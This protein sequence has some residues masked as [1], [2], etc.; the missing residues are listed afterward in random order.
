[1]IRSFHLGAEGED[2]ALHLLDVYDLSQSFQPCLVVSPYDR[3][4]DELRRR[5][6]EEAAHLFHWQV[7]D[8]LPQR[9]RDLAAEPPPPNERPVLWLQLRRF[10]AGAWRSF[11]PLLQRQRDFY[12]EVAPWM[13]VLAG[14]PELVRLMQESAAHVL[15]GVSV[16]ISLKEEPRAL[17]RALRPVRW[18]HLSD[19]HFAADQR[20]HR[21]KTLTALLTQAEKLRAEGLAPDFV[22]LTGDVADTGKQA[23]YQQ[24]E[25]FCHALGEKLGLEPRESFFVVPGNH[26][27]DRDAIGPGDRHI[28][29]ALDD[30]V[31]V[32][33]ILDDRQTMNLLGRRLEGFYA[34]TERLLGPAR[35][36]RRDKPWRVEEREV[37]DLRVAVVQLNSAW[38]SGKDDSGGL[39]IGEAQAQEALTEAADAHLRVVLVHHP[40]ADLRDF[41]R[42]P[43]DSRLA[44]GD[45]HFLLRG[46]LH[47]TG[48]TKHESPD[49]TLIELA[50]GATYVDGDWPQGFLLTEVDAGA[51]EGRVRYFGFSA[52]GKGFWAKDTLSYENLPDGIWTFALPQALQFGD[53][54]PSAASSELTDA[55]RATATVRYRAAA[56]AVHG[57]VRFVGFADHRPR[58]NVT[59]PELFVPLRFEEG[60][61]TGGGDKPKSVTTPELLG[62][63][64]EREDEDRA[65]R[66]VVLG[67]PGSGKT[68]FCRFATT[69]LA[70]EAKLDGVDAGAEILPLFLA[71]RDYVREKTRSLVDFLE[72]Q[73]RSQLQLALPDGFLEAALDDGRAVLLLDGLDEVGSVAEREEI[74]GRVQAFFRRWPKVP[75]LVTS[76][77]AGYEDAPLAS[78]GAGACRHLR[79]AAFDDEDLKQFVAHWYAVQ[80]P[81]DPRARDEGIADLLAA[82]DASPPVR[83]LAR[84][85]MLAT[86][87]ALVHRYE[88]TLP[89]ERAALYDICVKTLVETWPEA[90]RTTFR[91]IDSGLQRVY[92]EA[93]AYRMQLSRSEKPD[94]GILFESQNVTIDRGELVRSLAD[95]IVQ[96]QGDAAGVEK[97]RGLVE[98]WVDFLERGSGLLVEQRPGVFAFFHLSLMEYLAARGMDAAADTVEVVAERFGD[99][100]WREVCLLA[101]GSKATEKTFLDR[102]FEQLRETDGGWSFLLHC[103]REEAAFDDRQRAT[104][105]REVALLSLDRYPRQDQQTLA[106]LQRFSLRHAEW[107]TTWLRQSVTT[108]TGETLRGLVWL[109]QSRDKEWVDVLGA[110]DDADRVAGD[111]LD[112]WPGSVVGRW[113]AATVSPERALEAGMTSSGELL[114]PRSLL[115]GDAAA[116][117]APA[118]VLGHL[119]V[120]SALETL[121]REA[122]DELADE[123]RP[124]GRGL[125]A[126]VRILPASQVLAL[127]VSAT[128]SVA[129]N[130]EYDFAR[131]F[132]GDF[133]RDFARYFARD[134]ARYFAG[135]FAR[136][137]AR[138]FARYFARYFARAFAGD[139]A[140]VFVP[141]FALDIDQEPRGPIE[142]PSAA[143]SSPDLNAWSKAANAGDP[144]SFMKH[145]VKAF[146]RL[147]AEGWIALMTTARRP[148]DERRVYFHRRVQNAW[149][150]QIWQA[151]DKRFAEASSPDL[152]AVYYTLGFTQAT[153]TWQWPVTERWRTLLGG[154]PPAHW[155]PRSQWHLCWLLYDDGDEAHRRGLDTALDEGLGD[156]ERPGAA[157]ALRELLP[158][159]T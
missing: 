151:V 158:R 33:E 22:F 150:L 5:L 103:L 75:A 126:A 52:K 146:T 105:V 55:R 132:A 111:L 119:R 37:G 101:V 155:L 42:A 112:F 12:R 116:K 141:D 41:D 91:E 46:H 153:T 47:R 67:D 62:H 130:E 23:E 129:S 2:R 121:A 84:N 73:A 60:E 16:R 59:V 120:A 99:P 134:F 86:L 148:E 34:F 92:L 51:G 15:T 127:E 70:G 57:S 65:R 122:I 138:D 117:L 102:L 107:A 45:V 113:V 35:A 82:M 3:A 88:A 83:E 40:T 108:A 76:R 31:A 20:W 28:L 152:E 71:F 13:W 159:R 7:D 144:D 25:L 77:V 125:P 80:E 30:Q 14:S 85:P 66:V 124:G 39:V 19:C 115:L 133:A 58:P 54:T 53:G 114:V 79:L 49:G 26:D 56:A 6:A 8:Q 118:F 137:F 44:A 154:D 94:R 72:E 38:T 157:A 96:R 11:L 89:G 43:L 142:H 140:R 29:A 17:P 109:S 61:R 110:R 63:L 27:V 123:E 87:I 90:R 145:V 135:D 69:F 68:T 78:T 93:L 48:T 18:L 98:R 74:R 9:I 100:R 1:M 128:A 81:L 136:Y 32:E 50:A 24:A 156:G 104:I 139:F 64:L 106:E 147:A 36:W 149:L 95:V 4:L 131:Y 10:D 143:I 97:V 21:R